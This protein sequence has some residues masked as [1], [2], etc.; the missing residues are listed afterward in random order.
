MTELAA[1]LG[2]FRE[3]NLA[4]KMAVASENVSARIPDFTSENS[5]RA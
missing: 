3:H 5:Y 1:I 4:R 2:I